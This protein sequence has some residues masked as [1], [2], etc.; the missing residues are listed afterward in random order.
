MTTLLFW[1]INK[2]PLLKEIV[3]LC[4]TYDVDILILAELASSEFE[5][6]SAI[7]INNE[8]VYLAL[9]NNLSNR[10][11]FFF[12]YPSNT[13]EPVSDEGGYIS[14]RRVSP[15]IGNDILVAGVHLSSKLHMKEYDQTLQAVRIAKII[16]EAE[17][18]VG[19]E[20]TI[21]IGDLNMNPFEVG[22]VGADCFHAVMDQKIARKRSRT[23]QGEKKLFFYNPMWGKM[24][25]TSPEPP[26]TYFYSDSS[27][28][29]YFWN[30]FDQVLLRPDLLNFFNPQNLKIISEIDAKSLLTRNNQISTVYSDHLP[31]IVKLDIERADNV[32]Q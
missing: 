17:V 27:Y 30:T 16:R 2:K 14:I 28:V 31:V 9:F 19:H 10:I 4:R 5:L 12:R 7:N 11:K 24:G 29:N 32:Y 26:G 13:I 23:V 22:V 25:D 6:L 1:N 8:R 21:V 18:K 20:R 15:P 3:S